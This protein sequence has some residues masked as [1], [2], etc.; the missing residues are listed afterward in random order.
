MHRCE[1][2][3][4]VEGAVG[5]VEGDLG[6]AGEAVRD[7]E[8]PFGDVLEVGEESV[9]GDG[10]GEGSVFGFVAEGAGHAAAAGG[11]GSDGKGK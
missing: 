8:V 6:A 11:E 3:D 7:E 4:E 2:L 9:F 10:V 1:G 5:G